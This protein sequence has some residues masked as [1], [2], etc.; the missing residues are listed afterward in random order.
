[1]NKH[2]I[3]GNVGKEPEI[4]RLDSGM[5]IANF[6]IAVNEYKKNKETEEDP[7]CP[8]IDTLIFFILSILIKHFY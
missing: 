1:M 8:L 3:A 7:V 4:K 5:T 2:F 6:T